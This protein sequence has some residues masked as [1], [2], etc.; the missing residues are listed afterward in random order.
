MVPSLLLW[1]FTSTHG[2]TQR[3]PDR[4]LGWGV[5]LACAISIACSL[6]GHRL[7][8]R[9]ARRR[10]TKLLSFLADPLRG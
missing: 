10:R 5:A 2:L 3:L 4:D 9:L 1:G 7:G 8:G 6:G